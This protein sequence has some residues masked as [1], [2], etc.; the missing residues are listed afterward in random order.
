MKSK[1]Q[2]QT[3]QTNYKPKKH[4]FSKR[5]LLGWCVMLPSILLF[6]FFVWE[7]LLESVRLSLFSAK[8]VQLQEFVGLDNYITV[9]NNVSFKAAF[10]NTFKYIGWSLI[11]GF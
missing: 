8:G 6:T 10:L 9:I 7:P 11:I 1:Q 3:K 2:V 5:D 4:K